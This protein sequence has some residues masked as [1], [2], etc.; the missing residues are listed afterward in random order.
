MRDERVVRDREVVV[1]VARLAVE[2]RPLDDRDREERHPQ[3]DRKDESFAQPAVDVQ[4]RISRTV[5]DVPGGIL[6]A[7]RARVVQ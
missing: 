1:H 3:A 6:A 4:V 5:S 7:L 2:D